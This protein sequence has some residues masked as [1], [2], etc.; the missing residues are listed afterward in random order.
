MKYLFKVLLLSI[1]PF[2]L[3]SCEDSKELQIIFP[4]GICS[5]DI[6]NDEQINT[7]RAI[8]QYLFEREIQEEVSDYYI[9][10]SEQLYDVINK[11]DNLDDVRNLE[12]VTGMA[13]RNYIKEGILYDKILLFFKND[14]LIQVHAT[15]SER[16]NV[17]LVKNRIEH[18]ENITSYNTKE[19]EQIFKYSFSK[20]TTTNTYTLEVKQFKIGN[21]YLEIENK[22]E[23]LS[24]TFFT[25]Y[26]KKVF[27]LYV[28]Y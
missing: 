4:L 10:D 9:L 16:E 13:I 25:Y 8:C 1:M 6:L 14:K 26:S 11:E 7:K 17:S 21:T 23:S 24:E 5:D 27:P 20:D 18:I 22:Y 12:N 19:F 15:T 3:F 28:D 2:I